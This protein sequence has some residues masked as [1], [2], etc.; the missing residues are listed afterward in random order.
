MAQTAEHGWNKLMWD[1]LQR[2]ITGIA[3][4]VYIVCQSINTAG[5][6]E[7]TFKIID[8][9]LTRR[10]ANEIM[11]ALPGTWLVRKIAHKGSRNPEKGNPSNGDPRTSS[12]LNQGG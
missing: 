8:T 10:A 1:A 7:P 9:C 4:K 2:P 5:P 11:D 6:G 12:R 3:V